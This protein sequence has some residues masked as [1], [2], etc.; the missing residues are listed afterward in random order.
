MF[1]VH[2]YHASHIQLCNTQKFAFKLIGYNLNYLS[3]FVSI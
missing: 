3:T 1:S 2:I